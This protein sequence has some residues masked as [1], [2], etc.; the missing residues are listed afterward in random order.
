M[1]FKLQSFVFMPVFGLNNGMVPIVAFNYGA[2]RPDRIMKTIKLSITYAVGIMLVGLMIFQ[3]APDV[4]LNLFRAEGDSGDMLTILRIISL[5]FLFAGYAIVC[6][7]VFQALGHGVLSLAVSVVRQL[8]VLLP[9][10]FLL[11]LTGKLELVW[12]AFPIGLPHRGAVLPDPVHHLPAPGVSARDQAP[13]FDS[14]EIIRKCLA[15]FWRGIFSGALEHRHW[16]VLYA[17][18]SVSYHSMEPLHMLEM[19]NRSSSW[20]Q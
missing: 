3:F 4:M 19:G 20:I 10:G 18:Y 2:R 12:W 14:F 13:V 1:Y 7:S 11:S 6:S 16:D 17:S 8:V 9:V 15:K 5:S